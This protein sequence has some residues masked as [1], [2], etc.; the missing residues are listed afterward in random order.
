MEL[1]N[2]YDCVIDYH[3]GKANVVADALSRKVITKM[4]ALRVRPSIGENGA[5][6]AELVV[7]PNWLEQIGQA[8]REDSYAMQVLEKVQRGVTGDFEVKENGSLYYRDRV[9][10]PET[11]EM[12]RVLLDEAHKG[13]FAMHPG[14]TKLYQDLKGSYW[15]PGMK[16]DISEYVLKCLTCQR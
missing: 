6:I 7:K 13:P 8:Q 3:P 14:S 11:R 12:R 10:V 15:W 4:R 1:I 16:K 2:D 5:I 9:Y